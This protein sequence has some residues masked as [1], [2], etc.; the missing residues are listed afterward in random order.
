MLESEHKVS[1]KHNEHKY[2][3]VSLKFILFFS[4]MF[5]PSCA[6]YECDPTYNGPKSKGADMLKYYSYPKRTIEAE[7][8]KIQENKKYFVERI[9]FPSSLNFFGTE[10][11][12]IDYYAQKKEGRFPAVLILPISGGIDF[13]VK[14][15]A[16]HFVTNGLNCAILHNR[17]FDLDETRSAEEVEDYFRQIVF[18]GRQ[19]LDYLGERQEV[20]EEKLGC[21]GFSLGGIKASLISGVDERIKCSVFGL[22]G[23]SIADITILSGKKEMR[24]YIQE[25]M[26]MGIDSETV[27]IELSDKVVTDPLILG[28]YIDARNVLMY[29]A[30]FDKVVPRECCEK[31]RQIIGGPETVYFFT[32]HYG[33]FLYLPYAEMK[34]LNFFKEK[35][36]LK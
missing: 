18:D 3:R 9:E 27:Y 11:I 22:A 2:L 16:R 30:S 20:D 19:V 4:L 25:L 23:G 24:D 5:F 26:E 34:S 7:I 1:A 6:H 29:I 14:S 33:S 21:M 35:F 12:R 36:G 28:E 10:E 13:S 15:F 8:E 31:L 17:D 32:G